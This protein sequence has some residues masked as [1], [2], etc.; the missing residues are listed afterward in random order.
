MTRS[1]LAIFLVFGFLIHLP[2]QEAPSLEAFF[3]QLA[4]GQPGYVYFED[5]WEDFAG[6]NQD[7][8]Q[9][10]YELVEWDGQWFFYQHSYQPKME[11]GFQR[12]C[13]CE[14]AV[15]QQHLAAQIQADS[16]GTNQVDY[17]Y[18]L[19][20]AEKN[21]LSSYLAGTLP[22]AAPMLAQ[23][24]R[25]DL[26]PPQ[27]KLDSLILEVEAQ[28]LDCED[29]RLILDLEVEVPDSL[30][31]IQAY[32]QHLFSWE[33][34]TQSIYP[35]AEVPAWQAQLVKNG[36]LTPQLLAAYSAGNE[37]EESSLRQLDTDDPSR[38]VNIQML[39]PVEAAR[40]KGNT[41]VV[42][43]IKL[44]VSSGG[45]QSKHQE[46]GGIEAGKLYELRLNE[47]G[48]VYVEEQSDSP[49]GFGIWFYHK[50]PWRQLVFYEAGGDTLAR[51]ARGEEARTQTLLAKENVTYMAK[52]TGLAYRPVIIP[53]ALE[54]P[55]DLPQAYTYPGIRIPP[56]CVSFLAWGQGW[57]NEKIDAS[58]TFQFFAEQQVDTFILT[59]VYD[60]AGRNLLANQA[61]SLQALRE[62]TRSIGEIPDARVEEMWAAAY[63]WEKSPFAERNH[64][65][66]LLN[67]RLWDQ[68]APTASSLYLQGEL[69]WS[70]ADGT[71]QQLSWR[72]T[73][74]LGVAL[75]FEPYPQPAVEVTPTA[76]LSAARF[77]INPYDTYNQGL[78]AEFE[79][80]LPPDQ[81]FF[82]LDGEN[83]QLSQ[84]YDDQ[85][86]DLLLLE[87][88]IKA[89]NQERNKR[90]V[91]PYTHR[92][93]NLLA[94]GNV[95]FGAS[96][97]VVPFVVKCQVLPTPQAKR[98]LGRATIAYRT[99]SPDLLLAEEFHITYDNQKVIEL[100]VDGAL[101]RYERAPPTTEVNGQHFHRYRLQTSELDV[102]VARSVLLKDGEVISPGFDEVYEIYD[103]YV[104]E[105]Y[106]EGELHIG[107]MYGELQYHQTTVD[108]EVSI[109]GTMK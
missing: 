9:W 34:Q 22:Y 76:A 45:L 46:L 101:L 59:G 84:W 28:A 51:F 52:V 100:V 5:P 78:E 35:P 98:A 7:N 79:L 63:T 91:S 18:R 32:N 4:K 23:I 69:Y 61:D 14:L 54:V 56:P 89:W 1:L 85:G 41:E 19:P 25:G 24:L 58:Y 39:A 31:I 65:A 97:F 87:E 105:D 60:D 109:E 70:D 102:F 106:E 30:E 62:W 26:M 16:S 47:E 57:D 67:I 73:I 108:L 38:R 72:D 75:P 99:F 48:T 107:V 90:R 36:L 88:Q 42:G 77:S 66:Y 82:R 53:F 15:F 6:F 80:A 11:I 64:E 81:V 43:Q 83:S 27:E 8:K 50:T 93:T 95:Y 104:P 68:M 33:N 20:F 12:F 55:V 37:G 96:G 21:C 49:T 74:Q 29:G 86:F 71:D 10:Y 92:Y 17:F 2:A 3:D 94:D 103:L 44:A 40:I 13:A